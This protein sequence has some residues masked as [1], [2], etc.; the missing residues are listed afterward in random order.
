[1]VYSEQILRVIQSLLR[2]LKNIEAVNSESVLC[3]T[4]IAIKQVRVSLS[5]FYKSL[6]I[7]RIVAGLEEVKND[8]PE[9]MPFHGQ[10]RMT[11]GDLPATVCEDSC[12]IEA[13]NMVFKN[14]GG[15]D[16]SKEI[17][18]RRERLADM[19]RRIMTSFKT[20]KQL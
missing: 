17:V 12:R 7:L 4:Y 5:Q 11:I 15:N 13:L 16:E 10:S 8:R 9:T 1:M 6:Q 3:N 18:F 14:T 2:G 20:Q 19:D